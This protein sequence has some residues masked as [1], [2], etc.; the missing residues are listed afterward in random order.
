MGQVYFIYHA[1]IK[2]WF[3]SKGGTVL[4]FFQFAPYRESTQEKISIFFS[5]PDNQYYAEGFGFIHIQ[6]AKS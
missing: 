3:V 6:L 2:H 1:I 5:Q 4:L